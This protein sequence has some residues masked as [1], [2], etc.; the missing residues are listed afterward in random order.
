MNRYTLFA[1]MAAVLLI[2]A[3]G[4]PTKTA[5]NDDDDK[6]VVTGSRIPVKGTP[7]AKS[8]NGAGVINDMK[9][10]TQPQHSPGAV[11]G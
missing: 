5:S 7:A 9:Q 11:G 1:T 3:C 6:V 4:T 8:M 2:A 10:Q